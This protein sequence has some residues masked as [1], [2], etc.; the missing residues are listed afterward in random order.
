MIT[1]LKKQVVVCIKTADD[2]HEA[3]T[4]FVAAKMKEAFEAGVSRAQ[5]GYGEDED[6][7]GCIVIWKQ[8]PTEPDYQ[9]WMNEKYLKK[10]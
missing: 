3:V 9:A 6:E 4:A 1:K 8:S 5:S 7:E 10:E 2:V